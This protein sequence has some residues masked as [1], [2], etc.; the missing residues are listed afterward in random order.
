MLAPFR[1]PD[2]LTTIFGKDLLQDPAQY[3]GFAL[4]TAT[5][6]DKPFECVGEVDEC[7][8]AISLLAEHPQ[9]QEHANVNGWRRRF[10]LERPVSDA[11][12][13]PLT[14][15][16]A[17]ITTSPK[18][19]LPR[20]VKFSELDDRRVALWGLGRETRAFR[21]QLHQRLPGAAISA[22]IDDSI[23]EE[24]AR[25]AIAHADVLVR[26][27]GVSIYKPLIQQTRA[28][29]K[30]VTTATGLWM[31]ERGGRH[32]IGVTGTKGKSTTATII[33]HLLSQ[34]TTDR[35]RGEHRAPGHRSARHRRRGGG[36]ER[37][38]GRVR[39]LELPDR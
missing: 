30:P 4:L 35:A 26:S 34:I 14:S 28:E 3:E 19:C 12:H 24:E 33:A 37:N 36:R 16:S 21:D 5:G 15:L 25:A 17:T 23:P 29:G 18:R 9:W 31:A 22:V 10:S 8:A 13:G 27:P 7:L 39:A 20:Y 32:V 6:G 2:Q 1:T 38:L 11:G